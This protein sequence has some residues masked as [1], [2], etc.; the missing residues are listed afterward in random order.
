MNISFRCGSYLD[1]LMFR[2]GMKQHLDANELVIADG[3]Y[4]DSRCRK[5]EESPTMSPLFAVIRARNGI[6]KNK[7]FECSRSALQTSSFA[8][9]FLPAHCC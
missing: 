1:L 8:S 3:G 7:A 9:F 2:S 5:Y 6:M 4:R